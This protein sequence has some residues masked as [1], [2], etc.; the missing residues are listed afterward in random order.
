MSISIGLEVDIAANVWIQE[1]DRNLQ[2]VSGI[3][4]PLKSLQLLRPQ[5][6][7]KT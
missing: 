5:A 1:G 3:V 6:P 4:E 2:E 7:W